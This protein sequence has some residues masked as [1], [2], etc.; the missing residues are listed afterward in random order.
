[1]ISR[2]EFMTTLSCHFR[3]AVVQL[4][5]LT[6]IT[7]NISAQVAQKRNPSASELLDQFKNEKVFWRQIE[8]AKKIVA[9]QD[10]SV[11][12]QLVGWLNHDDRHLRGNAALIFSGLGDDRGFKVIID[13]IEDRSDRPEGQGQGMAPSDGRYHVEAQI[14]ADRYYA[15]HLLA[16]LKNARAV[17]V[18]VPLLKDAELNYKVA[19]V[20][21]EIGERSAISPLIESLQDRSPDVRVLAIQALEKLGANE[22]LPNLRVLLSDQ[23][24]THFR[25]RMNKVASV[26]EIARDAIEKLEAGSKAN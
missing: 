23:E 25:A 14:R 11:L 10:T 8:L 2:P 15:V 1:M 9:L 17:P 24:K 26:S 16:E 13:M 12:P 20:L 21:G 5:A 4:F 7:V 6:L 19:W 3:M 22:A 18:L